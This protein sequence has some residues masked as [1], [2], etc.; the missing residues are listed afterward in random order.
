MY[1]FF[2]FFVFF[3]DCPLSN[4]CS[5]MLLKAIAKG[6]VKLISITSKSKRAK[7]IA[8]A[9]IGKVIAKKEAKILQQ[10]LFLF[11]PLNGNS[12]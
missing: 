11:H 3:L 2:Y 8:I 10:E 5:S 6:K 4:Y 9:I 7:F 1:I 12:V